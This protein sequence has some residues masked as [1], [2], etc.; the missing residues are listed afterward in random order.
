MGLFV[1][2]KPEIFLWKKNQ[3]NRISS[4]DQLFTL[5]IKEIELSS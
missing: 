1:R 2:L 3:K 5:T 4:K